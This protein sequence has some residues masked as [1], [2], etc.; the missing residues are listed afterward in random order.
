MVGFCHWQI[1]TITIT[2][3]NPPWWEFVMV[4]ICW[5]TIIIIINININ[6]IS[7]VLTQWQGCSHYMRSEHT[8]EKLSNLFLLVII[9]WPLSVFA[10]CVEVYTRV[11]FCRR[12]LFQSF[13]TQSIKS[14]WNLEDLSDS[15][16]KPFKSSRSYSRRKFWKEDF[17]LYVMSSFVRWR[18]LL[19]AV[20]NKSLLLQLEILATEFQTEQIKIIKIIKIITI[21]K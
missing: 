2:D 7:R 15:Q 13:T 14:R 1:P 3:K 8:C 6:I 16:E 9:M 21:I 5:V 17:S 12:S 4:G 19:L 20:K 18:E 11:F 10:S